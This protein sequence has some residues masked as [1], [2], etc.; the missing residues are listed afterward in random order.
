M[1]TVFNKYIFTILCF[2]IGLVVISCKK[3]AESNTIGVAEV[4]HN[5][6]IKIQ[7]SEIY[8]KG[9]LTYISRCIACHNSD[10]R[11]P[12]SVGPEVWGSSQEL[13]KMRIIYGKYPVDY[14]PKRT[15]QMMVAMPDLANDIEALYVY[16]NN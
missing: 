4:N 13:L 11:K 10:P 15:S 16:L 8:K 9:K 14:K 5:Q 3:S 12:G 2:F 1:K 6:D 7:N